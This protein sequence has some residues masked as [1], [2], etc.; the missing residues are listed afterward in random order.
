MWVTSTIVSAEFIG[1][2]Q[3][4]LI[5]AKILKNL[6]RVL[7]SDDTLEIKLKALDITSQFDGNCCKSFIEISA[8]F[9]IEEGLLKYIIGVITSNDSPME[10]QSK[11]FD[12]LLKMNGDACKCF[13]IVEASHQEKM[14]HEGLL[15]HLI[16]LISLQD[17][18]S[19][20]T[21]PQHQHSESDHNLAQ[22]AENDTFYLD[23]LDDLL[24]Y[25]SSTPKR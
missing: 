5:K 18:P 15:V 21:P 20:E 14:F 11:C 16:G 24:D 12:N 19:S 13:L 1:S 6:L 9:T 4:E 25:P 3:S 22:K 10:L 23:M 17:P 8:T 7:N 2:H